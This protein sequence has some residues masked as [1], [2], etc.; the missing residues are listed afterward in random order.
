MGHQ[1]PGTVSRAGA[2]LVHAPSGFY[3]DHAADGPSSTTFSSGG[4]SGS[5]TRKVK[6]P[7]RT[8][9]GARQLSRAAPVSVRDLEI[10]PVPAAC[11][12]GW[13]TAGPD[14]RWRTARMSPT[15]ILAGARLL[16]EDLIRKRAPA[17]WWTK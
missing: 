9:S 14:G 8:S 17:V 13:L 1:Q 6:P 4:I 2:P 5:I 12:I 3:R 16:R 15:C 11:P 10:R 7:C